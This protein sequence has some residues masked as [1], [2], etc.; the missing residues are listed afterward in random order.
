MTELNHPDSTRLNV[1]HQRLIMMA[2]KLD[3][4]EVWDGRMLHSTLDSNYFLDQVHLSD[5]GHQWL[6]TALADHLGELGWLE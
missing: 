6:A 4:V 1:H 2:E 5:A 3:G